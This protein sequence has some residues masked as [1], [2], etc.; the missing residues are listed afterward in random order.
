MNNEETRNL[1]PEELQARTGLTP[2]EIK[3]A[4]EEGRSSG[5]YEGPAPLN[6][7][8]NVTATER[9]NNPIKVGK[10]ML[11]KIR[12]L[13]TRIVKKNAV[14]FDYK[15]TV[16]EIESKLKD[17]T[18]E[19]KKARTKKASKEADYNLHHS[20]SIK[21]EIEK[22]DEQIKKL[23]KQINDLKV[24]K[25]AINYGKRK[26]YAVPHPVLYMK[27]RMS[28][29]ALQNEEEVVL[30]KLKAKIVEYIKKAQELKANPLI[31]D[32]NKKSLDTII[33]SL[34]DYSQ[35]DMQPDD[36]PV[37]SKAWE[38]IDN[39]ADMIA[40]QNNLQQ[41][42]AEEVA[43]NPAEVSPTETVST[44][45]PVS[46][47]NPPSVVIQ[48]Q[49]R[50]TNTHQVVAEEVV[51][52]NKDLKDL[53]DFQNYEEYFD[54]FVRQ[55]AAG[56]A[57]GK[58]K[59]PSLL[60]K[61]EFEATKNNQKLKYELK[62]TKN[63]LSSMTKKKEQA[64]ETIAQKDREI[65]EKDD[66]IAKRDKTIQNKDDKIK[67]LLSELQNR[68]TELEELSK[69]I[70]ELRNKVSNYQSVFNQ[71]NEK[72]REIDNAAAEISNIS[73][74]N[75]PDT[76]EVPSEPVA[77]EDVTVVKPV[78]FAGNVNEP[79]EAS[80]ETSEV[81]SEP[82]ATEDVTVVKPVEFADNVNEPVEASR[83]TSEIPSEPVATEDVTVV[84]PV[85]FA[86]NVNEPVEASWETPEV[87]IEPV[88]TEEN[89]VNTIPEVPS[90]ET[91]M[92]VFDNDEPAVTPTPV[93]TSDQNA[94]NIADELVNIMNGNTNEYQNPLQYMAALR[95]QQEEQEEVEDKHKGRHR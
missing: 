75:K 64:D 22:T 74:A 20:E 84:K 49:R 54:E 61:E 73:H 91:N 85:E 18:T 19:R 4:A 63:K 72:F 93:V 3:K 62:E 86:G 23:D 76:P 67:K 94:S 77:T 25:F 32:E 28:C 69:Q 24:N 52:P 26:F 21:E 57:A 2:D 80:R 30:A 58:V 51:L 89:I 43:S 55:R 7:D 41:V 44:V 40:K 31:G 46:V 36:I 82:V 45:E 16:E 79:V 92:P 15:S 88:A 81:P 10:G 6:L 71:A 33:A 14:K 12:K 95:K 90:E 27:Y 9:G 53:K 48:P 39:L 70:E 87:P 17:L 38:E 37:I 1:S 60:S 59:L 35:K 29:K 34:D 42:V 83:E 47:N 68:K 5:A 13:R 50:H 56:K 78:E 65:A 8:Q 11:E 66:I